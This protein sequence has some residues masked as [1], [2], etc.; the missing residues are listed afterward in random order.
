MAK[1]TANKKEILFTSKLGLNFRNKLVKCYIWGAAL[2]GAVT[3]TLRKV[4]QKYLEI[5]EIWCWGKMEK[6]RWAKCVRNEV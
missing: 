4:A 2:C 5:S 6:I 3:W 1:A